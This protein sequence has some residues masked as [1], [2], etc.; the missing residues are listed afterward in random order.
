MGGPPAPTS[1]SCAARL[2]VEHLACRAKRG[3]GVPFGYW[4]AGHGAGSTYSCGY[5]LLGLAT[6]RGGQ[7]VG[8]YADGE[9]SSD[10]DG[11]DGE[12]PV[13]VGDKDEGFAG[14]VGMTD[15]WGFHIVGPGCQWRTVVNV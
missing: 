13:W 7:A 8:T 5:W 6:A 1:S 9:L 10:G 12:L 11:W 14:E 2:S 3:G 4:K 15:R